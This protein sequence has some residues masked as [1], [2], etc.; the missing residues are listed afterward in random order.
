[1]RML[2]C[3]PL[4]FRRA[5]PVRSGPTACFPPAGYL[6]GLSSALFYPC[7]SVL[8]SPRSLR[9]GRTLLRYVP[10][11][12][13]RQ[14]GEIVHSAPTIKRRSATRLGQIVAAVVLFEEARLN[15]Q[16]VFAPRHHPTGAHMHDEDL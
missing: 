10:A 2:K 15:D 3:V 4:R 7:V 5:A 1:M 11:V 12:S 8:P 13:W 14:S 6:S 9:R 16:D